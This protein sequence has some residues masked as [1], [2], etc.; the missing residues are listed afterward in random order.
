MMGSGE[1]LIH[2]GSDLGLT[3]SQRVAPS[4]HLQPPNTNYTQS[5]PGCTCHLC[6][7]QPFS[8]QRQ[9]HTFFVC[10]PRLGLGAS[11]FHIQVHLGQ[12]LPSESLRKP[13]SLFRE[14]CPTLPSSP[15][16]LASWPL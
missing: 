10:N 1:E 5:V 12:P 2:A 11:S 9:A 3:Q 7:Y 15:G 4:T 14:S 8:C 13:S 6:K 16:Q